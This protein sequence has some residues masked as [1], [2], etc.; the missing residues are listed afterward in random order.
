MSNFNGYDDNNYGNY[1]NQKKRRGGAG[2]IISVALVMVILGGVIGAGVSMG[3]LNNQVQPALG[4]DTTT[5]PTQ[6]A[7][8]VIATPQPT[9][10]QVSTATVGTL[11]GF[12]EE[13]ANVVESVQHS[14]VGI[15]NF[16]MVSSSQGYGSGFG[17][18]FGNDNNQ[19]SQEPV[20]QLAGSGSGVVY[21]A[22]GYII[23]NYH[24][25]QSAARIT[26]LLSDGEEIE[27][28]L[29]GYDAVQDIALLKID[30][31]GL[32]PALIGDSSQVRTGEFAIA[33]GSPL[34]DELSGTT[35]FG[36]ISYANR[37]LEI[38]GAYVNMIQTDA[39]INS[40][41]SGG[42]LMNVSGHVIGINSRKS[43]GS[44]SSGT[45]IEGIGFAI[46]INDVVATVEELIQNGKI[47]RPGLGISGQEISQSM[48][49]YYNLVP[50]ILVATV[51]EG[52]A[53]DLAGI[54]QQDI[55]TAIDGK[56]ISSQSELRAALYSHKIGDTISLSIYRS[57]ESMSV[58]VTL[59]EL[60]S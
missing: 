43:S 8:A 22:D 1:N 5:Q 52:S 14:V 26:V 37:T 10:Q 50:G 24:V 46:P 31:T 42:A 39:A 6:T 47:S 2:V 18:P 21:S 44:T 30:R 19:Q 57:G 7:D 15:H 28:Q 32:A 34:G 11:A 29:I 9:Q 48:A 38:D 51:S 33:I 41:N 3:I 25:V 16:Q 35:T 20:E 59:E 60:Q 12:S 49:S 23:T 4:G 40:G 56:E 54:K 45:S 27:A 55:I 58:N 13:I 17:F 53:A 36:S